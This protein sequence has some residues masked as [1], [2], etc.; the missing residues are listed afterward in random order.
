MKFK[1]YINIDGC[2]NNLFPVIVGYI[3]LI[4][5]STRAGMNV[6]SGALNHQLYWSIKETNPNILTIQVST[7]RDGNSDTNSFSFD[8]SLDRNFAEKRVLT[9]PGLGIISKNDL[10]KVTNQLTNLFTQIVVVS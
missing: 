6:G 4:E 5:N 3:Q 10:K 9:F 8:V 2:A 1:S 7:V